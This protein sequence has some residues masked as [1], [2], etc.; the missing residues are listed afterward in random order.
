MLKRVFFVLLVA[1]APAMATPTLWPVSSGGNGHFYD[2]VSQPNVKWTDAEAEA[3]A[4]SFAGLP[5]HLTTDTSSAEKNFLLSTFGQPNG[6]TPLGWLG[7]YQDVTAQDYSEPGGGW[8]WITGEPWVFTDWSGAAGEPDNSGGNQSYLRTQFF[9]TWDDLQN[10]PSNPSVQ[11]ISG[12]YVEY[13]AATAGPSL[14][15]AHSA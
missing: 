1:G 9:F 7:G 11:F 8:R 15:H 2:F 12:Y 13:E 14:R 10:D 6:D 5:G 3:A 4:S